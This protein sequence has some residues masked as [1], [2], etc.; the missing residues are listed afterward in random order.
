MA[1]VGIVAVGL[2]GGEVFL[3]DLAIDHLQKQSQQKISFIKNSFSKPPFE[4]CI[5]DPH[6]ENMAQKRFECVKDRRRKRSIALSVMSKFIII[7]VKASSD[8]S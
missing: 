4:P 7:K 1:M 3:V 6:E 5:V 2:Q 8:S